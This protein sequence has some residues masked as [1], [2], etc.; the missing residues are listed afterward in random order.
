MDFSKWEKLKRNYPIKGG[1]WDKKLL[2]EYLVW[3]CYL[4][5]KEWLDSFFAKHQSD[6]RLAD[7]LFE[8]LL[9]E[10]YDGSGSQ[11]GAAYYIARL[12][13]EVLRKKKELLLAAQQNE[14]FWKRP[15]QDDSYL[16]WL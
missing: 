1:V 9:N 11:I 16:E 8:F 2:Y 7:L 6:E 3:S 10:D 12:D 5:Y 15:F 4:D 13:R 14:V